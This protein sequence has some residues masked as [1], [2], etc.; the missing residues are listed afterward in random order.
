MRI[1]V[2]LYPPLAD[3]LH[4]VFLQIQLPEGNSVADAVALLQKQEHL[5]EAILP[6]E[7]LVVA[8]GSVI[9]S[10]NQELHDGDN[11]TLFPPMAGG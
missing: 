11:L 10:D 9:V 2:K 1:R 6:S 5:K 3:K 8:N 4:T 7:Y